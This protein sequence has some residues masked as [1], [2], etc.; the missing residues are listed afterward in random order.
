MPWYIKL[1]YLEL[2]RSSDGLNCFQWSHTVSCAIR[3]NLPWS[4]RQYTNYTFKCIY[5]KISSTNYLP[6]CSALN[7]LNGFLGCWWST[8]HFLDH[9]SD[10]TMSIMASRMTGN[11]NV[12]STV[13]SGLHERK[14]QSSAS[15]TLCGV[16]PQ[17]TGGFPHKKAI[18]AENVS[19][20]WR[21]HYNSLPWKAVSLS[22]PFAKNCTVRKWSKWHIL[23]SAMKI[24]QY[25][26]V[27]IW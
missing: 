21:H 2:L 23:Q 25:Y 10:F 12:C 27:G 26:F 3:D 16:N 22:I 1:N 13:C 15:L 24:W 11:P 20:S 19:M 8:D 7:T 9:Y 4:A 17:V 5:V 14:H 18:N 6:F